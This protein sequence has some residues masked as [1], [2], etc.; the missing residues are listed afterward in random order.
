MRARVGDRIV[1]A[2]RATGGPVRDGEIIEVRTPDGSPPYMV[3]WTDTGHTGLVFP[4]TD[5][6]LSSEN[7]N[8]VIPAASAAGSTQSNKPPHVRS[9][10]VDI[11]LYES[12]D[13]T[14][15]HA[16]LVAESP[17]RLDASGQAHREPADFA[18]PEIG[19][20]VAVARALRRLAD[21][22]LETASSD[23]EG[24]AGRHSDVTE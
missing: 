1:V 8:A 2:S 22:L 21:R 11:D 17:Q 10:R 24:V 6:H 19:D 4:G 20:E 23:L 15:A 12:D 16:V 14:T 3:R 9:W 13:D 18:V 5:A 7:D